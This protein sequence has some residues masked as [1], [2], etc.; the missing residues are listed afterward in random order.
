MDWERADDASVR[1]GASQGDWG[2]IHEQSSRVANRAAA[3]PGPGRVGVFGCSLV[4]TVIFVLVAI[5]IVGALT[6]ATWF[7][8]LRG[9][10]EDVERDWRGTYTCG[11]QAKGLRLQARWK[12]IEG[13]DAGRSTVVATA[14]V[15]DA[16]P[17]DG[18]FAGDPVA[19][20]EL[21]GTL[22]DGEFN[23]IAATGTDQPFAFTSATGQVTDDGDRA[24]ALVT[25]T[26][27][28]TAFTVTTP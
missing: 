11:E 5:P 9:G 24:E 3:T 14:T 13:L 4:T 28:C 10:F 20:M 25:S 2:A 8:L 19:E 17:T 23:L 12:E 26:T 1:E 16:P 18:A 7:F 27:G 15:Y 21:E 6:L 22:E